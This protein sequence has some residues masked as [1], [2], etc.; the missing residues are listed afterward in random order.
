MILTAEAVGGIV[1]NAIN[2]DG[3]IQAVDPGP[4]RTDRAGRRRRRR[5]GAGGGH[6]GRLG[7]R[8]RAPPAARSCAGRRS[9][10]ERGRGHQRRRP[11]WRRH[12]AG[13]G[14]SL[15]GGANVGS[16]IQYARQD[17]VTTIIADAGFDAGGYVPTSAIAYVDVASEIDASATD[18]GNGGTVIVWG[19]GRTTFHG[20]IA[21]AG[22]ANGGDG[23]F[24]ETSGREIAIAG[25]VDTGAAHG[26]TGLWLIDP[27][28]I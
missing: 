20:T 17:S 13:S 22:G 11:G 5:C 9:G 19:N 12:R 24:V 7:C 21:A 3:V 18:S 28:R 6:A 8:G 1:D 25:T 15:Q 26:G 27:D 2:M 4:R 10:A 16:G 23:G 14:G